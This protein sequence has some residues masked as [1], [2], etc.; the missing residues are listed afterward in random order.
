MPMVFRLKEDCYYSHYIS[1]IFITNHIKHHAKYPQKMEKPA[2]K[3]ILQECKNGNKQ[4]FK[5]KDLKTL[6]FIILKN[7]SPSEY[8]K[9][10]GKSS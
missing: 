2:D 6:Y 7:V 9:P 5:E 8:V 4:N 1:K 10:G 3:R